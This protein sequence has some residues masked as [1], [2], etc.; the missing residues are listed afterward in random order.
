[1]TDPATAVAELRT[2]LEVEEIDT[3]LFRGGASEERP[4][5]VFG[6]LV[7]AQ[8][9]AAAARDL[10]GTGREAHSLHAYFLR[11]GDTTRPI[12]YRVLRDFD[13]GSFANRRVV[14][15]QGG[16]PILNLAASFHRC[17]DGFAHAAPMAPAPAPE[18]CPDL[19]TALKAAGQSFP[20]A[21]LDRLAAFDIRPV[22]PASEASDIP[23]QALWFRLAAPMDGDD[24]LR[25]VV[26]AYAS[27]FA[28][29]STAV[30]PHS[31]GVFTPGLQIASLDHAV[32]FHATPAVDSWL[33]YTMDSPWAGHARGFARGSIY[34]RDGR[35]VASAAQE[36]LC[37]VVENGKS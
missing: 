36:G 14:A 27:D 3:D 1:M 20:R 24:A 2:L 18:D 28:L 22:P 23:R 31:R 4:G 25:R 8:A 7:V 13:G 32:W 21:M 15:M 11:A 19:V 35:L 30:L 10:A 16:K 34:D 29:V 6:G 5:R 12:I 33:L 26:L 37:R 17:E 9:L